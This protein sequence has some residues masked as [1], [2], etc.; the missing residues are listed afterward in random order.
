MDYQMD[1]PNE[2]SNG[3]PRLTTHMDYLINYPRK[4]KERTITPSLFILIELAF[5]IMEF[6]DSKSY[7]LKLFFLLCF[8]AFSFSPKSHKNQISPKY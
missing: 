3:L 1:Y 6:N 4:R 5:V 8:L 2:L 7:I